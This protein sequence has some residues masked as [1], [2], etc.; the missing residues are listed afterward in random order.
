[1]SDACTSYRRRSVLLVVAFLSFGGARSASA[2]RMLA[3][4]E[5]ARLDGQSLGF[6]RLASFTPQRDSGLLFVDLPANQVW[7]WRQGEPAPR[8]VGG[9]GAGPGEF[10]RVN[11]VG[12]HGDTITVLDGQHRRVER[13]PRQLP[14]RSLGRAAVTGPLLQPAASTLWGMM[15]VG[16]ADGRLPV[17]YASPEKWKIGSPGRVTLCRFSLAGSCDTLGFV[18][19]DHTLYAVSADGTWSFGPQRFNDSPLLLVAPTRPEVTVV[20]RYD[21]SARPGAARLR[22]VVLRGPRD[23]VR[24]STIPVPAS[25]LTAASRDSFVEPTVRRLSRAG[26][27]SS[28][29]RDALYTPR[30]RPLVEDGFVSVSGKLWLRRG[31]GSGTD[32]YLIVGDRGRVEATVSVPSRIRL[33]AADEANVWGVEL[34]SDDVPSLVRFRIRP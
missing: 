23:T 18:D 19:L 27:P 14:V 5:V 9:R 13:F 4:T 32:Q 28:L 26:Y 30:F 16:L 29:V 12:I 3:L 1:M 2:Q 11:M 17:A 34:D 31:D 24:T 22:I 6:S 33:S 21:S 10:A 20:F 25:V 7:Q 8:P 15:P